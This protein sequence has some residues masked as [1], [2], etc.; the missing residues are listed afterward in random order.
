[1]KM[2]QCESQTSLFKEKIPKRIMEINIHNKYA[3][4]FLRWLVRAS[5][6]FI[7]IIVIE[8]LLM[9]N[10]GAIIIQI[11]IFSIS[12]PLLIIVSEIVMNYTFKSM[13]PLILCIDSVHVYR[14]DIELLIG[15][16]RTIKK[17]EIES[18]QVIRGTITQ[19]RTN[20]FDIL[21]WRNSPYQLV[22]NLKN[23]KKYKSGYKYP[24]QINIMIQVLRT[25]WGI[26]VIDSGEGIGDVFE[27]STGNRV[28]IQDVVSDGCYR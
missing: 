10:S 16:K 14:S 18:V 24:P 22:F 12:I 6:V 23:N 27:K 1:M 8:E 26:P 25:N 19:S 9:G 13:T 5:C 7:S 28:S 21:I 3:L 2:D 17:N 4:I 15:R 20:Q 11:I